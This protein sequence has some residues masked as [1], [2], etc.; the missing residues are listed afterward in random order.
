MRRIR[1]LVGDVTPEQLRYVD[2][3]LARDLGVF[4]PVAGPCGYAITHGHTH[5]SWS[6]IVPYDERGRVRIDGRTIRSRPGR[7]C[8]IAPGVPHEE[9]LPGDG[10]PV[11]YAAVFVG[12]RLFERALAEHGAR[13][14]PLRGHH[15]AA[16]PEITG[17]I[18]EILLERSAPLPGSAAIVDAAG[19][20]L[21]HHLLR[22]LLGARRRPERVPERESIRRAVEL[23]EARAGHPLSARDLA[24]AAGMS[25][26]HFSREFKRETGR[27]PQAYLRHV[28]LD[29]AKRLLAADDRPVTEVALDCGFCSASHL[30]TAFARAFKMPPSRYRAM[31]RRGRELP[32]GR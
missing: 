20:R 29:R 31:L 9:L 11:R 25:P 26:F 32:Q 2:F 27:T 28:R 5:P 8:A 18:R 12:P 22:A 7:I 19:V 16:T 21:V 15:F 3:A 13:L 10:E 14:P 6:F 4:M 24:R 23:A 1:R 17:A 30:A